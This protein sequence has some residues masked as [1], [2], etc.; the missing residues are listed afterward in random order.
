[1]AVNNLN[2][3][4]VPP[5]ASEIAAAVA[6][7]SAATIATSVAAAVPT[8]TQINNSVATNSSAPFGGTWVNVAASGPNSVNNVTFSSLSGY[9]FY[10]LFITMENFPSTNRLGIRFNGDSTGNY[11][12]YSAHGSNGDAFKGSNAL[13]ISMGT[14]G[15]KGAIVDIPS[16]N[17]T[18]VDKIAYTPFSGIADY[19][20]SIGGGVWWSSAAITSINVFDMQGGTGNWYVRLV[21]TN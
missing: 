6:A 2:P 17:S 1:M 18:S 14:Q 11:A 13:I 4:V 20:V 21:G 9:R 10:R 5:T 15:P 7:P 19:R 16:A 3:A 12:S 8:L